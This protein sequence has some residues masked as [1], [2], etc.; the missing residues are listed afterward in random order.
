[1]ANTAAPQVLGLIQ[2]MGANDGSLTFDEAITH[3]AGSKLMMVNKPIQSFRAAGDVAVGDLPIRIMDTTGGKIE[4]FCDII[5]H[6]EGF[7]DRAMLEDTL[8]KHAFT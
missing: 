4:Q 6:H 3:C 5:H 1:M 2:N 7:I 8:Y